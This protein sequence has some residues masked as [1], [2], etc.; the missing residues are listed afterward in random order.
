M[1]TPIFNRLRDER[2]LQC[3]AC[4]DNG[5]PFAMFVCDGGDK[6]CDDHA[7]GWLTERELDRM[8]SI[9]TGRF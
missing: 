9:L 1:R 5:W 7:P 4:L 8:F 2:G 6:W 3:Q